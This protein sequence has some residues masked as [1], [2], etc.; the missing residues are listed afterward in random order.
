[1][2]GL[3]VIS[4]SVSESALSLLSTVMFFV[5]L[6]SDKL[7]FLLGLL[8]VMSSCRV[9]LPLV[10]LRYY[11]KKIDRYTTCLPPEDGGIPLCAFATCTTSKL[12]TFL[13]TIFFAVSA[14]TWQLCILNKIY[15][16]IFL[17]SFSGLP[18]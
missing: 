18:Q 5:V 10:K 13:E 4:D 17:I 14:K 6:V 11:D 1:M 8:A 16:S 7:F 9:R 2:T 15:F 3:I 12:T